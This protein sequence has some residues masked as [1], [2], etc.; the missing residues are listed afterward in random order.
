[1]FC[2]LASAALFLRLWASIPESFQIAPIEPVLPK[3]RDKWFRLPSFSWLP[4]LRA[5]FS[6][7][8]LSLYTLSLLAGVLD[9]Q[10]L[11]VASVCLAITTTNS[12][13]R[14]AD[15]WL[16]SLPI[17]RQKLFLPIVLAPLAAFTLGRMFHSDFDFSQQTARPMVVDL[18]AVAATSLLAVSVTEIPSFARRLRSTRVFL[19]TSA[20]L[21]ALC[22]FVWRWLHPVT[23]A[24][25]MRTTAMDIWLGGILPVRFPSLILSV[26]AIVGAVY[27]LAYEG[28]RCAEVQRGQGPKSPNGV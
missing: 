23:G 17:S 7:G 24:N 21:F 10:F 19:L 2:A 5:L 27:W 4:I 6:T 11:G 26:V 13:I 3:S 28:F 22:Y 20:A 15:Q 25:R 1:V 12:R 8:T 14:R 18:I 16:L 9:Q